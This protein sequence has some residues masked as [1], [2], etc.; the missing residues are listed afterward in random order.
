MAESAPRGESAPANT[1]PISAASP[2]NPTATSP[3]AASAPLASA[4]PAS[5]SAASPAGASAGAIPTSGTTSTGTPSASVAPAAPASPTAPAA[6]PDAPTGATPAA[7]APDTAPA[8]P[9]SPATPAAAPDAPAGANP[10]AATAA[11]GAN[12]A[13]TPAPGPAPDEP[14]P[15]LS[16]AGLPLAR[17]WLAVIAF[18]WSGQAVSLITS[19]AAGYAVVWYVTESTGSALVLSALTICAMLPIGLV[20]PFGGVAADRHNRKL[21]MIAADGAVGVVSLIAGLLI[22]AGDVSIPLLLIV[23]VARAVGQAFH[24]PAMMAAMP[25]LVPEKHLLRINTLDQL[26]ASV[27]GIGAPAFGIFLYTTF[28]FSAVM[29]LDFAGAVVAVAGLMLAKI[30]TVI[31]ADAESQRTMANLRDGWRA[32]SANRGLVLLIGGVMLG[33]VTFGP[34]SALCPLMVLDHFGGDG[35]TASIAEAAFGVGMLAGSMILMAWGGGRRLAGLIA[36]AAVIVGATTAVCGLLPPS[37]FA[38]YAALMAVMAV[39]CAWFNGPLI[40]LVQRNVPDEKMGRAMGLLTA[41][42]GLATPVGVALGGALA[43][44]TGVAAFFV[45]DGLACLALGSVMYLFKSVRALDVP[46]E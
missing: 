8:T 42:M 31:D 3:N 33:M 43:E 44:V 37:G 45:I 21:I 4:A 32:V 22:L 7:P 16:A 26:L 25:L 12:P 24:G 11:P 39:A 27:A 30:P 35:Y 28:G 5:P 29:F 15:P 13:T 41:S 46:K 36:V 38:A 18:I 1:A 19:Y 34:L 2:T 9:A 23:C 40:T 10:A 14:A 17:N 20:S 6:T